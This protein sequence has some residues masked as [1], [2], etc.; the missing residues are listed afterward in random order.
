MIRDNLDLRPYRCW[1][2][3]WVTPA[4]FPGQTQQLTMDMRIILLVV[5][6][7]TMAWGEPVAMTH[8]SDCPE[9][10]VCPLHP[11][12]KCYK[13][14]WTLRGLNECTFHFYDDQDRRVVCFFQ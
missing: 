12:A 6:S 9:A 13:D 8:S 5:F 11:E 3:V 10:E 4:H 2:Y 14:C 7:V 1:R